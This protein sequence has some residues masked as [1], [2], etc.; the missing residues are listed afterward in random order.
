MARRLD[1]RDRRALDGATVVRALARARGE[2]R[3]DGDGDL[4]EAIMTTDAFDKRGALD[5]ELPAGPC[6]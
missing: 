4:A 3:P 1:R 2:L 6:A 5:V